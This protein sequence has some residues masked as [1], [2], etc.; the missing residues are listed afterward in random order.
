MKILVEIKNLEHAV[1]ILVRRRP[2][3]DFPTAK[4]DLSAD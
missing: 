3:E 2:A 4:W 1:E